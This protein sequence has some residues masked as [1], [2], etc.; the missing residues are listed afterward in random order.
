MGFSGEA[1]ERGARRAA[2][3]PT[4][5]TAFN[6]LARFGFVARGVLHGLIGALALDLACGQSGANASQAGAFPHRGQRCLCLA[7]RAR[8][9]GRPRARARAGAGLDVVGLAAVA[10]QV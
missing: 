1:L 3:H 6:A 5:G 4:H 8:D 9:Q 2:S 10:D 7:V